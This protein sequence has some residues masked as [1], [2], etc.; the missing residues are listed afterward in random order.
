MATVLSVTVVPDIEVT[1]VP[2]G[3]LIDPYATD[4]TCILYPLPTVATAEPAVVERKVNKP[5][6]VAIKAVTTVPTAMLGLETIDPSYLS[7]S[8]L[9]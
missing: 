7:M 2:S 1:M 4:P 6:L 3:M 8:L 9:K 5:S